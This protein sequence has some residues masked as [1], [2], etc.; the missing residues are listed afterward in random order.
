MGNNDKPLVLAFRKDRNGKYVEITEDLALRAGFDSPKQAIGKT[1]YEFPLSRHADVCNKS[2]GQARDSPLGKLDCSEIV[3]VVG[4]WVH[5][6]ASKSVDADDGSVTGVLKL[7]DSITSQ[8]LKNMNPFK[9][10][11]VEQINQHLSFDEMK[12]IGHL[13]NQTP[14][15]IVAELFGVTVR[16]VT[17]KTKKLI[18]TFRRNYIHELLADCNRYELNIIALHC[19]EH[20]ICAATS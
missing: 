3:Q 9:G 15:P 18:R 8:Y 17:N 1:D 4:G 14:K 6:I 16:Q 7:Q 20:D 2:D 13:I 19:I 11:F 10:I 5:I 12:L